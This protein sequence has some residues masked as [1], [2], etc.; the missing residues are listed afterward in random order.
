MWPYGLLKLSCV[1]RV[2][3]MKSYTLGQTAMDKQR[4]SLPL[5]FRL[6]CRLRLL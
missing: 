4:G 3:R 6:S 5:L 1:F 2:F